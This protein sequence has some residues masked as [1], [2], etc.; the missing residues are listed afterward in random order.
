MK[1]CALLFS[2][3]L[4][5]VALAILLKRE[6]MNV[7]PVYMSHR[8]G[9]NVT[10]KEVVTAGQLAR[11]LTDND[12]VIVK[13]RPAKQGAD[14]WYSEWGLV[15]YS[16]R[17]P[18]SKKNKKKRNRT[19]LKIAKDIGLDQCDFVALGVFGPSANPNVPEA[20]VCYEKLVK[21]TRWLGPGQLVTFESLGITSKADM[22][23]AVTKRGERNRNMLWNS[24]SCLMYF[25]THCGE[26][27]SCHE[28]V[29]AFMDAWGEDRTKY[30]KG[31]YAHRRK[32]RRSSA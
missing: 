4:D 15:T 9:G 2:G 19:F 31:T 22:L 26:C 5:S 25:N 11:P 29:D 30:R 24:E 10:K 7:V 12:L 13:R 28:R 23:R 21:A 32:R 27:V 6:G 16:R 20:D 8:H 14:A 18:V 3:G 1:S 17:L